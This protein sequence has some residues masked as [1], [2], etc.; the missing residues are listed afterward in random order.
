MRKQ[1]LFGRLLTIAVISLLSLYISLPRK[2][3]VNLGVVEWRLEKTFSLP[4]I[5]WKLGPLSF[6]RDLEIKQGLDLKGGTQIVLEAQVQD[7]PES[8]RAAALESARAVIARRIDLYGISESV[9]QTAKND[10]AYRLIVELPGV[11][12]ANEAKTLIGQTAKLEFWEMPQDQPPI[13]QNPTGPELQPPQQQPQPTDLTGQDLQ[14]AAVE[15]DQATG[16]PVVSLVFT[17]EGR[18]KF[19][20][21][22]K[23]NVGQQVGIY[24]DGSP[25]TIPVVK[26]PI[27][28]GR[29]IISGSMGVKEAKQLAISLNAGALPVGMTVVKETNIGA[30]L[31]K[32]SVSAS[33]RAGSVGLLAV[34]AFMVIIYR[35][36]GILADI[37]LVIYGLIT[38]T[39]YKLFPITLTLPGVAGFLL[40]IGMATDA[41]ILIFE[42]IKEELARGLPLRAAVELG[43]GRAWDSIKDANATTLLVAFILY[44]PFEWQFL[45]TS[46]LVR[47]FALTLTIGI[48]ISL[49]TG[50]VV[51][52]TL[53]RMFYVK[54]K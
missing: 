46:G 36:L 14:K 5:E 50:I 15:F 39:I 3:P 4:G 43:F 11:T 13:S 51:S 49:F 35:R 29:A 25:L 24:L 52:R 21:I 20:E 45:N 44:N 53:I 10:Q 7:V 23:R 2:I 47:G 26:V 40:S 12:D 18:E 27:T 42:R 16:E 33:V 8:E 32:E 48:L 38:M 34:A 41:N 9:V 30:T 31:G 37:A 28:N 19:A 1:K 22:T 17:D 6:S 54:G